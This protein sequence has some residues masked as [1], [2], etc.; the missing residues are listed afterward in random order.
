MLWREL[1]IEQFKWS[2]PHLGELAC[3]F[4][5]FG[6]VIEGERI[7]VNESSLPLMVHEHPSLKL[8]GSISWTFLVQIRAVV[9]CILIL[10]AKPDMQI[11]CLRE[12]NTLVKDS[13]GFLSK[14]PL[15]S[16][17]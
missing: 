2:T 7:T 1:Y 16:T 4:I 10:R 6:G 15:Q 17:F 3:A 11:Q 13:L 12:A 9:S 5:S 14:L 8:C